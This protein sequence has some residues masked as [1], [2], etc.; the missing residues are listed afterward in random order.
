MSSKP[1]RIC[2]LG[3]TGFVGSELVARLAADGHWVRV[4]TRYRARGN[5]LRVLPTLELVVANVH[6]PRVLAELLSD[7]DVV[8]N[9]I[10]IL[11]ERGRSGAGFKAVHADF[12]AKLVD[13]ARAG[14]VRRVLHMSALGADAEKGP[15]HYLRTKGEGEAHLRAAAGFLDATIFRPSVIFG[16]RDSL[17]NRFAGLLRLSAGFLPL[18]RPKARF[19]PVYVGDVV[20]AFLRALDDP[21]TIGQ[22]YELCGPEIVTLEELVRITAR[23]AGLPC[24]ILPLPD[25]VARMQAFVMDFVPG[26]P[27]STD[28]YRSLTVD[29]V[30][31]EDGFARLGIRP[32]PMAGVLPEYLRRRA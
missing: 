5:H 17:T 3:G 13:A 30:C 8:I 16:P 10:G 6:E 20:E 31:R 26:K 25:F 12:V 28:N 7:V 29:N 27:F 2:V 1:L 11:N 4:P 23:A 32:T 19:A 15:S 21:R 14:R 22:S 18:A 24:H 9:L